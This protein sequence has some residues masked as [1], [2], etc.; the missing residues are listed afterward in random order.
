MR[1]RENAGNKLKEIK[2]ASRVR[3][4]ATYPFFS[5]VLRRVATSLK[6]EVGELLFLT[7]PLLLSG[8]FFFD[9]WWREKEGGGTFLRSTLKRIRCKD[10]AISGFFYW[11]FCVSGC[12]RG[13]WVWLWWI[14]MDPARICSS[15][16]FSV[17]QIFAEV[18]RIE[19]INE[20]VFFFLFICIFIGALLVIQLKKLFLKINRFILAFSVYPSLIKNFEVSTKKKQI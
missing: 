9:L 10:R 5:L 14:F 12:V 13:L 8:L 18:F 17:H 11:Y 1:G 7:H 15:R 20:S 3:D 19:S 2:T 16:V 4:Y 6:P